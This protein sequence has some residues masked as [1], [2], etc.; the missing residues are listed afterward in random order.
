MRVADPCIRI[1]V[2]ARQLV[3]PLVVYHLVFASANLC[4]SEFARIYHVIADED[5]KELAPRQVFLCPL[6]RVLQT[7]F[8]HPSLVIANW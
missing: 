7:A 3:L 2:E 1:G 4:R 6:S 5:L 8:R